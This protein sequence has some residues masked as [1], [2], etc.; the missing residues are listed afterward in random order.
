MNDEFI[1]FILKR[2]L[3]HPENSAAFSLYDGE[4][5]QNIGYRKFADDVM[6][7]AA[8]LNKQEIRRQNIA[9]IAPNCYE[10]FVVLL[11]LMASGNVPVLL[12][13]L[14]P[15]EMLGK[16]IAQADVS[17]IWT[18]MMEDKAIQ[19]SEAAHLKCLDYDA[20][21]REEPVGIDDLYIDSEDETAVLIAT[22]GT[23]GKSKMVEVTYGNL[24]SR[25]DSILDIYTDRDKERYCMVLP[26]FHIAGLASS[27]GTFYYGKTLC[28]GR[29]IMYV[30]ADL[31]VLNPTIIN[32]VPSM[33]ETFFKIVR[34]STEEEL[35]KYVGKNL[36]RIVLG[37]SS[38]TPQLCESL[39]S[40]GFSLET[41]YAMTET[42]GAGTWCEVKDAPQGTIGKISGGVQCRIQDGELLFKGPSVMKGYYKDP[43]AT[44]QVM[45]DGWLHTGDMGYCDEQGYYFITGR[46]KNVIIL[47]NGENV[48]PEE[49]EDKFSECDAIAESMVYSNG[50]GICADVYTENEEAAAAFIAAYNASMPKY[51]Q[52]YKVN[53]S[54]TPLEKTGSGKIKRKE[55]K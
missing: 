11:A 8:Y 45:E 19:E 3:D 40:K 21:K 28:M 14:L 22:S 6:R 20:M 31:P 42:V 4:K 13:P 30:F 12:N 38:V 50:K 43:E 48:N 34:R 54:A 9:L 33:A 16:Q 41:G 37:G 15:W 5:V 46:K 1:R 27:L 29:G 49:I 55:N 25:M 24:Q 35:R 23:T 26:T 18:H 32:L 51:R 17:M 39:I 2:F 52:V 44:A 36:R 47:S 7:A 10:W 53:Y